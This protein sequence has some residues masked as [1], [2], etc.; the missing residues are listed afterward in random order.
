MLASLK[1]HPI[2][3]IDKELEAIDS[4]KQEINEDD[5]LSQEK[6]DFLI[7]LFKDTAEKRNSRQKKLFHKRRDKAAAFFSER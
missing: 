5:S 3:D 7:K 2:E 6:K 4:I 1:D